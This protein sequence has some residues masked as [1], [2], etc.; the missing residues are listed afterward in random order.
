[1]ATLRVVA[2][3]EITII[4]AVLFVIVVGK[5]LNGEIVSD[6]LLHVKVPGSEHQISPARV[7]LLVMTMAGAWEYVTLVL[8]DYASH[9]MPEMPNSLMAVFAGSHAVYLGSKALPV[10]LTKLRGVIR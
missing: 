8:N 4:L 9:K 2:T 10:L 3:Y 5:L 1:M 6:G 7:Q